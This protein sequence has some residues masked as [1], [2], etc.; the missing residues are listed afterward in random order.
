MPYDDKVFFPN[1]IEAYL[2]TQ[3]YKMVIYMQVCI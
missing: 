1:Y 2:P 3:A